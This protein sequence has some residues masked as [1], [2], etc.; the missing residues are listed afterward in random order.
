LG[1]SSQLESYLGVLKKSLALVYLVSS[2]KAIVMQVLTEDRRAAEMLRTIYV[3][4]VVCLF[5]A[6]CCRRDN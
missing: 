3:M 6:G 1:G 5:D 4:R 2:V